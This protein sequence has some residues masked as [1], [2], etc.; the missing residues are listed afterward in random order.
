MASAVSALKACPCCGLVQAIPPFPADERDAVRTVARCAR[1]ES[2]VVAAAAS[3][4]PS[5]TAAAALAALVL[6]PLAITLP[7]MEI[8][9]FG[10]RSSAS[11]WTGSV[12][13]LGDGH[14]FVG[15]VVLL[16]SVVLPL[17]KL[18]SL[19]ALTTGRRRF[20]KRHRALTYRVVEL[21]GRWGMLDVLLIAVIV[22]WI[23]VGDLVEVTAGPAAVAF[24]ACVLLSLLA[25]AWF[26]PHLLWDES[27]EPAETRE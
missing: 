20:S 25:S 2:T 24:T 23:K 5:W 26:D 27:E 17:G 13:L 21:T 9:R 22:A 11:I 7:I 14:L 15:G 10:H 6:Y 18:V 19:F 3:R 8:A 16:C 4:A 12:G 1:C